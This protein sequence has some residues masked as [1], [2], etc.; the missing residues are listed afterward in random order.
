MLSSFTFDAGKPQLV[1]VIKVS[2]VQLLKARQPISTVECS[3]GP[4]LLLNT[5]LP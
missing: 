4:L 5:P 2:K 3:H 1:L